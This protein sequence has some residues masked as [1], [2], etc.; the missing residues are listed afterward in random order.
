ML[1]ISELKAKKLPELQELANTLKVPKYRTLKKLDLVYH[2]IPGL[3]FLKYGTLVLLMCL[4]IPVI[5][6]IF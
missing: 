4:L 6:V 1:E 3:I 5:Q 2:D